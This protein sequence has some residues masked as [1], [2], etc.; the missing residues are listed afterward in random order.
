ME[1]VF[2]GFFPV[3]RGFL[4]ENF[5]FAGCLI[6][7]IILYMSVTTVKKTK[8]KFTRAFWVANTVE[9]LERAAYYGV[10]V[11]ITLYLSNVLGFTDIQ[12]ATIAGIFSACLYFLPTF[13]GALADKIGFRKSM[14]LAFALLTLGYLGLGL[15]PNFLESTGLVEYGFETRFTG[16]RESGYRYGIIPIMVLIVVGGSFIKSV[17]SGTVAKETD[18]SNR[19][20]GFAIFYGMVNI[21]AFSG[22]VLVTPLR[23]SMGHEGM[24]VLNYF[25]AAMTFLAPSSLQQTGITMAK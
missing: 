25:S 3:G 23:D 12:A 1:I 13:S 6:F 14:L 2:I 7:L 5:I 8:S 9:L 4:K 19:A 22:K 15:F 20:R 11:V 21:G 24:I 18:E 10:F 17:I 16:L